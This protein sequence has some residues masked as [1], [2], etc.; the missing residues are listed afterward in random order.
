[1]SLVLICPGRDMSSWV[2]ALQERAPRLR[3]EIWPEIADPLA[4]EMALVWKHP[5]GILKIFPNLKCI[6][7]LGAG[8][9]ALLQ[10]NELPPDVPLV[11]IVDTELKQSMAEYVCLGALEHFRRF[12]HYQELQSTSTWQIRT[13]PPVSTVGVGILG[14]GELGSH[15]GMKLADIGFKVHGWSRSAKSLSG[16][17]SYSGDEGL[18]AFLAASDILVCL[19]PLTPATRDFL[20]AELFRQLP[21]GAF[22]I[23]VA[24]GDHL[25]E[26]DLIAAIDAGQLSGALLDVFRE[27]PLPQ[28][29]PFWRHPRIRVTPHIASIT[30]PESAVL[31]ILENY[32]RALSGQPLVNQVDPQRGY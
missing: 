19:L 25:V 16:I 32:H 15:V 17:A 4:V 22:L 26:Q 10:D 1:M 13:L 2:R 8:V 14:L 31:Q 23:N 28:D 18:G 3:I 12:Q 9:D 7:S 27:E 29:H 21:V 5:A 30:N 6:S 24:R 11:R 20:N